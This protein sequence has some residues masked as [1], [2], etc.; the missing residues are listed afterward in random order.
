[1][2][3]LIFSWL[4]K[5]PITCKQSTVDVTYAQKSMCTVAYCVLVCV[6]LWMFCSVLGSGH[7]H[8]GIQYVFTVVSIYLFCC[9]YICLG[10]ILNLNWL[11]NNKLLLIIIIIIVMIIIIITTIHLFILLCVNFPGRIIKL[12]WCNKHISTLLFDC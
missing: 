6:V 5:V 2:H 11:N 7:C 4:N 10:G 9:V 8:V 1:M 12:T 3:I